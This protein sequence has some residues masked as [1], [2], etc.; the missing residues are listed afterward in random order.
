MNFFSQNNSIASANGC[1]IRYAIPT[2]VISL[3]NNAGTAFEANTITAGGSG[4]L[5]NSQCTISAPGSGVTPSSGNTLNAN[6]SF[7]SRLRSL[8]QSFLPLVGV[9]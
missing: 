5:G 7:R 9:M 6:L 2:G 8:D 3:I 4:T 1:G